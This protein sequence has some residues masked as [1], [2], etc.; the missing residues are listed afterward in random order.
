MRPSAARRRRLAAMALVPSAC[1]WPAQASAGIVPADRTAGRGGLLRRHGRPQ[2]SQSRV[3]AAVPSRHAVRGRRTAAGRVGHRRRS[4]VLLDG[5]P[6]RDHGRRS[7]V[8]VARHPPR[9]GGRDAGRAAVHGQNVRKWILLRAQKDLQDRRLRLS[10]YFAAQRSAGSSGRRPGV[11]NRR[12]SL[13]GGDRR[14]PVGCPRCRHRL[15]IR[16]VRRW[17]LGRSAHSDKAVVAVAGAADAAGES[18][19]T[20]RPREDTQQDDAYEDRSRDQNDEPVDHASQPL[21]RG[22]A[23]PG[24]IR[25]RHAK[26]SLAHCVTR[27]SSSDE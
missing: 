3:G 21:S 20:V 27:R 9:C 6:C 1:S 19:R 13:F 12:G 4:W 5:H 18:A 23:R 10:A 2:L 22:R 16:A 14:Q 25:H 7:P 26:T 24:F 15:R 8:P 11:I 17:Y